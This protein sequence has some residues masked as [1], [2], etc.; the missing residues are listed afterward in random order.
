MY[1]STAQGDRLQQQFSLLQ[2]ILGE[3]LH[4]GELAYERDSF[5]SEQVYLS[6]IDNLE[7][8]SGRLESIQAIDPGFIKRRL[9]E[10]SSDAIH[11]ATEISSL[12]DREALYAQQMGEADKLLALNE[13]AM[14]KIDTTTAALSNITTRRGH[15]AV[16]ME[17]AMQ[18][19]ERMA[20]RAQDYAIH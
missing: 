20:N 1:K 15:A 10:L 12:K 16:D 8:I 5:I 2:K 6:A 9:F 13:G 3:T 7:G 18:E 11:N 17:T 19:L 4:P 14:T